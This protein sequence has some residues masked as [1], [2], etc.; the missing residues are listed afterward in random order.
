MPWWEKSRSDGHA[1]AQAIDFQGQTAAALDG[2]STLD[3]HE[4][5]GWCDGEIALFVDRLDA[6]NEVELDEQGT[7]RTR[8]ARSRTHCPT[9]RG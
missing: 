3:Q 9:R 1:G 7:C 5:V 8:P 2:F 4:L 6:L